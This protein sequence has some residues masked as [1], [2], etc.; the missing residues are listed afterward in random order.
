[1]TFI[2]LS[3]DPQSIYGLRSKRNYDFLVKS[4]KSFQNAVYKFSKQM[5]EKEEFP[6]IFKETTL[7]MIFKGG[8][9]RRHNLTDNRFI[10]SKFWFPRVAEGPIVVE[11]L[12]S[13]LIEGSSRYQIGGQPGHRAEELVFVLKSVISKYR[14][15]GKLIIIQTSD[16]SKF[17]DKEKLDDAI[18]TCYKRG[19]DPKACRLC[20]GIS[21]M[22][23][24]RLESEQEQEQQSFPRKVHL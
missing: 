11:G 17:F 6:D 15:E 1:M 10:H 12:K 23:I 18:L 8:Q 7:H 13:A 9:G 20:C 21:L 16:I 5:F 4:S 3:D 2:W 22:K 14:K 24:L 19:A